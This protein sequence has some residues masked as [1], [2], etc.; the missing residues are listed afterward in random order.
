VSDES[1]ST[2]PDVILV[3]NPNGRLVMEDLEESD[4]EEDE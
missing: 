4:E 2:P 3:R 1:R